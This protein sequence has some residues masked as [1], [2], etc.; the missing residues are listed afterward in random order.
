MKKEEEPSGNINEDIL[1][2]AN[3]NL[4]DGD[5]WDIT[6][7]SNKRYTVDRSREDSEVAGFFVFSQLLFSYY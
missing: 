6:E 4:G 2:N 5:S 1:E 7:H 3:Q